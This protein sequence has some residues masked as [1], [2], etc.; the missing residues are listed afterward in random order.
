[1]N[2][3]VVVIFI[4]VAIIGTIALILKNLPGPTDI[5]SPMT[6]HGCRCGGMMPGIL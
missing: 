1:M 5:K 4:M 6:T 2:I 3:I